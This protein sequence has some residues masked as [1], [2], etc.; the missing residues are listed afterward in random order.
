MANGA[1]SAGV[2]IVKLLIKMGV[3]DVILC[4]TKGIIYEGRPAGMNS[5]KEEMAG[6]PIKK[7]NKGHWQMH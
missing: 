4:D 2:A 1:G 7:K 3:K 5:F 6:S